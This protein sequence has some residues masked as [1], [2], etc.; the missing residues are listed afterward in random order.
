MVSATTILQK[1]KIALSHQTNTIREINYKYKHPRMK[2]TRWGKI[3]LMGIRIYLIIIL[4][5]LLYR[6]I[7]LIP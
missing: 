7:T 2:L 3:A 6:F 4:C 1:I 5:I